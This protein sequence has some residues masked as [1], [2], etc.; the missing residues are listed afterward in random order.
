MSSRQEL[1][2][3]TLQTHKRISYK[4]LAKICQ[5]S[6][7]TVRKLVNNLILEH[8]A[9]G[10]YGG[11]KLYEEKTLSLD[12]DQDFHAIAKEAVKLINEGDAIFLG[13]GV[14]VSTLC[15]YLKSFRKLTV[16]TN[17]LYSMEL[18]ENYP[19]ITTV[20]VGGLY[21]PI[22]RCFSLLSQG[23]LPDFHVSKMFLSGSGINP[24]Y[25]V[26]HSIPSNRHTEEM[27]VQQAEKIVLLVDKTKFGVN[28][29][30]MLMPMDL[31]SCIITNSD[32]EQ[33]YIAGIQEQGIE[34]ILA[35]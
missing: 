35:D 10:V 11:A 29:P 20:M 19:N 3:R 21:Q 33:Q 30:F 12:K 25:G 13:P 31:I 9:Q 18:L 32:L 22:N 23:H 6:V 34:L 26:Y 24:K 1:I 15:Y 7:P 27:V 8:K 2:Y 4:E 16:F 5:L 17:S 28:N 14:T